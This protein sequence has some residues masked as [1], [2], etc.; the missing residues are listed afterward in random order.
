ML[1]VTWVINWAK[2]N[3]LAALLVGIVVILLVVLFINWLFGGGTKSKLDEPAIQ[4]GEQ[5]VKDGNDKE[6]KEIIVN[7]V[8]Q[9]KIA[10]QVAANGT[11]NK[12]A[13]V[14]EAQQT[15]GNANR[16]QL[17]AEFDRRK[18]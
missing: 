1:G 3:K 9:E 16:D 17:Q 2:K 8:A 13:I 4:R 12:E 7:S 15:W 11:A 6:L 14:K 18:Q 5:A 10:D